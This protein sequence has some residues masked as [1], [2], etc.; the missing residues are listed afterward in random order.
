MDQLL[1]SLIQ[2]ICTS[3]FDL[4]TGTG[5]PGTRVKDTLVEPCTL[6]EMSTVCEGFRINMCKEIGI[7]SLR[8]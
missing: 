8:S 5:Y 4:F 6:D 3:I 7:T 1:P 2:L